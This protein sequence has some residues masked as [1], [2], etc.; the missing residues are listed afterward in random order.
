MIN[1]NHNE[2]NAAILDVDNHGKITLSQ[3]LLEEHYTK[4]DV[5]FLDNYHMRYFYILEFVF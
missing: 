3:A 1:K 4:T 2:I 5:N